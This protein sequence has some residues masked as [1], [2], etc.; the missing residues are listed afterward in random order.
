MKATKAR[1]GRDSGRAGRELEESSERARRERKRAYTTKAEQRWSEESRR[2]RKKTGI[3][4]KKRQYYLLTLIKMSALPF[5]TALTLFFRN[6]RFTGTVQ[7]RSVR[8]S[9]PSYS[10]RRSLDLVVLRSDMQP[11]LPR[12]LEPPFGAQSGK[13]TNE[14][15]TSRNLPQG[16][17]REPR[18]SRCIFLCVARELASWHTH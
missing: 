15:R 16:R 17:K 18:N 14:I 6:P 2:D 9:P 5:P 8:S 1:Q 3:K 7:W 11:P 13:L 10:I 12:S 4:R